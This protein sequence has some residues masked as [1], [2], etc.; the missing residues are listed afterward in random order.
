VFGASSAIN[1]TAGQSIAVTQASR[2]GFTGLAL[3]PNAYIWRYMGEQDVLAPINSARAGF[4][5]NPNRNFGTSGLSLASDRWDVRRV[6]V[7]EGALRKREETVRTLTIYVDYLTQ[8]PL[9]WITRTDR[10]RLVEVGALAYRF[11]GSVPEYESFPDGSPAQVFDPV[12]A[13][14]FNAL[15]GVGGWRRESYD[16][17]STPVAPNRRRRMNSIE[18]LDRGN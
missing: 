6:V 16:V 14:F 17:V 11:S 5:E 7:I 2:T 15:D 9:Y 12:A 13:S 8:L 10:R 18:M 1:P 4:P 3:R